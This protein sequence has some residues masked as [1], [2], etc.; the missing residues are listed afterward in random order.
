MQSESLTPFIEA[1]EKP[2]SQCIARVGRSLPSFCCYADLPA[3]RALVTG[4]ELYHDRLCCAH[5]CCTL[6]EL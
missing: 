4:E 1:G 3:G 2:L 5:N 6:P